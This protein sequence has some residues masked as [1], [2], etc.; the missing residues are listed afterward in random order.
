MLGCA[1]GFPW[2]PFLAQQVGGLRL[3][4]DA[5]PHPQGDWRAHPQEGS[6][7][8]PVFTE[9][10]PV[11]ATYWEIRGLEMGSDQRLVPLEH[12]FVIVV[13]ASDV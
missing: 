11:S 7:L 12:A 9:A 1:Q 6:E 3:R 4:A 13:S 10:R 2:L 5:A 8:P